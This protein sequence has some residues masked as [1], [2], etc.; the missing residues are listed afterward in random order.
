MTRPPVTVNPGDCATVNIRID[1]PVGMTSNLDIG[2]FEAVWT[3]LSNGML[4]A[5]FGSVID[6]RD[7]CGTIGDPTI[8]VAVEVAEPIQ[9]PITIIDQIGNGGPVDFQV[10]M[11]P[12][13][14]EVLPMLSLDG[15]PPGT[16]VTG[17]LQLPPQ[18]E[19]SINIE[20]RLL[21]H[22]T[23]RLLRYHF[24]DC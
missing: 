10:I 15:L 8:G 14:P 4:T 3:N 18:G 5:C 9:L 21:D 13:N 19:A 22:E 1:R 16:P 6:R 20:A 24:D 11:M 17:T 23:V 7:Y 12:S 2:C